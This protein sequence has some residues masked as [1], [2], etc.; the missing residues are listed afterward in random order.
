MNLIEKKAKGTQAQNLLSDEVLKDALRELSFATHRV[1]E[2]STDP[3]ARERA[4]QQL[5]AA[6]RF[7]RHLRALVEQGRQAAVQIEKELREP[8][9]A[10]DGFLRRAR[11]RVPEVDMPWHSRS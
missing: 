6:N 1:W 10:K 5:D 7:T 3:E 2:S 11:S 8:I 9:H 4:W